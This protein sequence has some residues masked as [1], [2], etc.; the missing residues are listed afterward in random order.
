MNSGNTHPDAFA[1]ALNAVLSPSNP[2]RRE[3]LL[4]GREKQLKQ[5]ERAIAVRGRSIFVW[6]PRGVG[7]TSVA[8]T[9]AFAHHPAGTTPILLTCDKNTSAGRLV[10]NL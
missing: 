2:I 8:Q 4:Q 10:L 6:G 3:E 9:S 5:I 7:K 1:Q